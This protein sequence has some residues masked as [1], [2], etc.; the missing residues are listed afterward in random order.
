MSGKES[1]RTYS[2]EEIT[3]TWNPSSC[4]HSTKCWK[5]LVRVFN[6]RERPWIKLDGATTA[7]IIAQIDQCPSGAISWKRKDAVAE[8]PIAESSQVRVETLEN[9]PLL[10]QGSIIV[11]DHSG[12]E[13]KKGEVTAF[14]RCGASANKPYCDGSHRKVDFKG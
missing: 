7:E 12:S 6:P 3:V 4:I 10:V 14:C 2:N 11:K 8:T 5:G 9:G 1:I 13:I